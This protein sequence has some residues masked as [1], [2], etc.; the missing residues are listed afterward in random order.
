MEARIGAVLLGMETWRGGAVL[1]D[2]GK[3]VVLSKWGEA[4]DCTGDGLALP[5]GKV[6][7]VS[8]SPGREDTESSFF[9]RHSRCSA[10]DGP[11]VL[12]LREV[13]KRVALSETEERREGGGFAGM[14]G[15]GETVRLSGME[16]GREE[17]GLSKIGG[18]EEARLSK[19]E[20]VTLGQFCRRWANGWYSLNG[21][22]LHVEGETDQ[23]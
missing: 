22:N 11:R 17:A 14:G 3:Q 12:F 4:A 23:V 16:G 20:E 10:K 21:D 2:L 8:F 7:S 15:R 9:N 1:S 5:S 19:M 6:L 13:S 18:R